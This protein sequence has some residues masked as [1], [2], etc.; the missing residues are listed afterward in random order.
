MQVELVLIQEY[1]KLLQTAI[2]VNDQELYNKTKYNVLVLL[3][4]IT[5][6]EKQVQKEV[7]KD[8]PED[9]E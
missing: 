2:Q 3:E 5:P 6:Q 9:K 4:K 7:N 1:I 8:I